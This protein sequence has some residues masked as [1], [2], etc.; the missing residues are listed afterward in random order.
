M[1]ENS[2]NSINLKDVNFLTNTPKSYDDYSDYAIILDKMVKDENIKNIGIVAPYGAGK[3]SLIKKYIEIAQNND[4]II[5]ISLSNYN[6]ILK[7]KT[8]QDRVKNEQDQNNSHNDTDKNSESKNKNHD[9]F[10]TENEIEKSILQQLFYKTD[11]KRTPFS[12]FA[13]ISN[14]I[15]SNIFVSLITVLLLFN[16]TILTL[17]FSNVKVHF[18]REFKH[19]DFVIWIMLLST[20]VFI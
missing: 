2:D 16:I 7:N 4:K 15:W 12:R 10:Q 18:L 3:S 1:K 19:N 11:N 6:S 17:F 8:K 20:F 13:M 14:K 9:C 5:T